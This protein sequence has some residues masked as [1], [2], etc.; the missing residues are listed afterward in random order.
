M[1]HSSCWYIHQKFNVVLISSGYTG[2]INKQRF[3]FCL[4][5]WILWN[6]YTLSQLIVF[7]RVLI[8]WHSTV[9]L[10]NYKWR[11]QKYIKMNVWKEIILLFWLKKINIL[12]WQFWLQSSTN[13]HQLIIVSF[14]GITHFRVIYVDDEAERYFCGHQEQLL[15]EVRFYS[16][17]NSWF[18]SKDISQQEDSF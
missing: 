8:H 1:Q 15:T 6:N 3:P 7:S 9:M 4:F 12:S 16:C 10:W 17:L 2:I 13:R 11:S 5:F 14:K 18:R